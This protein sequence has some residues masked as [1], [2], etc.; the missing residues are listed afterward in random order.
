[1][2]YPVLV[3]NLRGLES[4]CKVGV[5]EI[6]VFAAA[7]ESFSQKNINCSIDASF[8]RF[9]DVVELANKQG[10]K[11]RGYVSCVMGCP[12]EGEVDPAKVASVVQR[13]FD[14]GKYSYGV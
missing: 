9:K 4:A 12:Y 13:L 10:L 14:I 1:M 7:S 2:S 11:I 6:A 5:K 3:P 8:D